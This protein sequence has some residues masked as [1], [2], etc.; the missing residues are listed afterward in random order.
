[1]PGAKR[2]RN[3]AIV[4]IIDKKM[5]PEGCILLS[6]LKYFGHSLRRED[7]LEQGWAN[8]GPRATCGPS[9]A[10][11]WPAKNLYQAKTLPLFSFSNRLIP[12]KLFINM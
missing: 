9:N 10:F 4:S 8:Y 11:L 5:T 7:S 12:Y 2:K 3:V 6:K 1:M